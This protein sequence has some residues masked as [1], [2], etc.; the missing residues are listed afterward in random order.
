MATATMQTNATP[1]RDAPEGG[2]DGG[3]RYAE[4]SL[5]DRYAAE[6]GRIQLTGIQALARRP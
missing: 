6:E 1:P 2:R 5:D 4:F 3:P